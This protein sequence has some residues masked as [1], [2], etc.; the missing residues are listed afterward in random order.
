MRSDVPEILHTVDIVAMAS[1]YEGLSL[2][3]I[4]GMCVGKPFISSDVQGL[5]EVVGGYGLL[6][7]NEEV[8]NLAIIIKRL[9]EDADFYNKVASQCKERAM[10]YDIKKVVNEY[11]SVYS[12]YLIK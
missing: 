5:K 7:K 9:V 1:E 3:S 4:E 10:Q 2:S 6:F 11:N 8:S 12:K